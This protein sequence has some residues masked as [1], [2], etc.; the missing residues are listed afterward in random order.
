MNLSTQ[1]I[2]LFDQTNTS[3]KAVMNAGLP[4][5]AGVISPGVT[6]PVQ[7]PGQ[8]ADLSVASNYWPRLQ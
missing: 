8:T 4:V 7:V 3:A 6:V 2:L 5:H 1:G